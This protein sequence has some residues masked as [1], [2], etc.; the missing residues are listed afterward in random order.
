MLGGLSPT[1]LQKARMVC[2]GDSPT[3]RTRSTAVNIASAMLSGWTVM[4]SIP[5]SC[6]EGQ[7]GGVPGG[8]D[9]VVRLVDDDPVGPAGPGP[10]LLEARQQ[11][12]EEGGPVLDRDTDQVDDGILPGTGQEIEGSL[13]G[14]SL[15]RLAQDDRAFE[16]RVIPLGIDDRELVTGLGEPLQ[17]PGGD[18]RLAAPRCPR[19]QDVHSVAVDA[20]LGPILAVP[21]GIA[22]R[23]MHRESVSSSSARI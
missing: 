21:R 4:S 17:Q 8:G 16:R 14:G 15:L 7:R 10:Q 2:S 19:D 12:V 18:R 11:S 5:S 1:A 20:D 22:C 3:A 23:V 6:W 9:E 13:D